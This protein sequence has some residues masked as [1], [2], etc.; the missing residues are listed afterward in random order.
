MNPHSYQFAIKLATRFDRK[1]SL[2]INQ[3][4]DLV[5]LRLG[6]DIL[7]QL[8]KDIP[9]ALIASSIVDS[10]RTWIHL[11]GLF[12][13]V[14][15]D[16]M[17]VEETAL[18]LLKELNVPREKGVPVSRQLW[19]CIFQEVYASATVEEKSAILSLAAAIS[20]E[21]MEISFWKLYVYRFGKFFAKKMENSVVKFGTSIAVWW[22][23]RRVIFAASTYFMRR[24]APRL[25]NA[26]INLAPLPVV[27]G[28]NLLFALYER[29]FQFLL[30]A[31][32]IRYTISRR[33]SFIGK[34]ADR[35]VDLV[36][37]P[38]KT[39][40][41]LSSL[42]FEAALFSYQSQ[43]K[44]AESLDQLTDQKLR[45]KLELGGILAHRIWMHLI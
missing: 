36:Y 13:E 45:D 32:L 43:S 23:S 10:T 4:K 1:H 19:S 7:L 16:Q 34:V 40:S 29:R 37:L 25:S 30:G 18:T 24:C 27:K 22:L 15:L 44:I 2:S 17:T 3:P 6:K 8:E 42:P 41:Y 39:I 5:S 33:A 12:D 31:L 26:F 14:K 21:E 35:V 20:K 28:I 38:S 9:R 11:N